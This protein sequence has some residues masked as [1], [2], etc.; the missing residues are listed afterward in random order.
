MFNGKTHYFYDSMAM[1]NSYISLSDGKGFDTKTGTVYA[2]KL[3]TR[4]RR[5]RNGCFANDAWFT[6]ID[7]A[8]GKPGIEMFTVVLIV[9]II[10]LDE[11]LDSQ[12]LRIS[13]SF[14]CWMYLC[15]GMLGWSR[16]TWRRETKNCSCEQGK[17]HVQRFPDPVSGV[18]DEFWGID[19]RGNVQREDVVFF[20]QPF[21][22][23]WSVWPVGGFK[24]LSSVPP[25]WNG[26]PMTSLPLRIK[27]TTDVP[28]LV[29]G[30]GTC[31]YQCFGTRPM[32]S[33]ML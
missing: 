5:M 13:G 23:L 3:L 14:C 21:W 10:G 24:H 28:H 22:W 16:L 19:E 31:L 4:K 2:K 1:F 9:V 15:L 7:S 26:S 8:P 20:V 17:P 33:S 25:V 6:G 29:L 18:P 12:F 32:L 30:S 27:S 11:I